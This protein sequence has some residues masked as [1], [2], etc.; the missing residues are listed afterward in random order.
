MRIVANCYNFM[1]VT[2]LLYLSSC[3]TLLPTCNYHELL[4]IVRT[5]RVTRINARSKRH[6]SLIS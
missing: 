1:V 3:I 2:H 4:S 6:D 5:Q